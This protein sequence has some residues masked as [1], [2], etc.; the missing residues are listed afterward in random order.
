M[1]IPA[2]FKD[3]RAASVTLKEK[4]GEAMTFARLAVSGKPMISI[5]DEGDGTVA[6]TEGYFGHKSHVNGLRFVD[7]PAALEH[8]IISEDAA[9]EAFRF[10]M[11]RKILQPANENE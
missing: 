8:R 2:E 11:K 1:Q 6:L 3:L 5:K 10:M 4:L 9:M 7:L